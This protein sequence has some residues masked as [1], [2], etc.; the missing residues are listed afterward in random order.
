MTVSGDGPPPFVPFGQGLQTGSDS[1][2]RSSDNTKGD[3]CSDPT[4]FNNSSF[5]IACPQLLLY[6]FPLRI[7][8][9]KSGQGVWERKK[10]RIVYFLCSPLPPPCACS[11]FYFQT[12]L[13]IS[14]QRER[15]NVLHVRG[16]RKIVLL[17]RAICLRKV[18]DFFSNKNCIVFA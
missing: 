14:R 6:F 3:Y 1:K 9:Y 10:E 15:K 17:Y 12:R 5:P 4:F 8:Q 11:G 7:W 2:G 16:S 13:M 18:F